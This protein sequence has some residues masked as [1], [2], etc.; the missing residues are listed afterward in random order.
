MNRG[1]N[2]GLGKAPH[3]PILLLSILEL[4]N[5]K[6]IYNN[7]VGIT[8]EL[9]LSF[10]EFF[11]NLVITGHS[12]NFATPYFH[13]RTEPYYRLTAKNGMQNK[14]DKIKSIKS[15]NKSAELIAFAEID[16]SLFKLM[17]DPVCNLIMK[18]FLLQEFFSINSYNYKD[19]NIRLMKA[20]EH[21]ILEESSSTYKLKLNNLYNQLDRELFE[22]EVFIRSGVFKKTVPMIYDYSCCVT[23]M[24]VATNYNIQMVD[25]C[26]IIPFS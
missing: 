4:V 11:R 8:P 23:G 22:Q 5:Q 18:Q 6:L 14:L 16:P 9:V 10:E 2:K 26:H 24:K 13:M 19:G 7:R 15:I 1:F 21:E 17:L 25:A 3:K 20:I 12:N